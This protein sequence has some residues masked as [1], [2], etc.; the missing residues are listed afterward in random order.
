M[1][2][3]GSLRFLMRRFRMDQRGN[4][5]ML[6]GLMLVPLMGFVGVAV[7]YSRASNLRQALN[8]AIDSAALM[9]ARDAQSLRMTR[10]RHV[11][12]PG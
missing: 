12:R 10:S 4:V 11:S 6:F 9:A 7:D 5:M 2:K 1:N 3:L 8:A